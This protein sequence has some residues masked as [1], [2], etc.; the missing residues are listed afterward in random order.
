MKKIYSF[1]ISIMLFMTVLG[2]SFYINCN[3]VLADKPSAQWPTPPDI[4][5]ESAILMEPGTGAILYEKN[6]HKKMYP[7]SITKIMT[8]LLTLENC[9]MTDTV[10]YSENAIHSITTEDSNINCQIGEKM[11]VR[12]CLYALMLSSA[13][14]TA[15]A[16]AEHISGSVDKFADLMN[17]RAAQLGAKD[18]HFSNPNGLYADDHYVTAYDM[19]LIMKQAI[20]YP[21]FLDIIHSTVY[22]ILKNNKRKSEFLSY[23]RHKMVFT[24]SE[25]YYDGVIGG[26]TGYL[27]E[28]GKTLVTC[29]KKNNMT[30]ICVVLK[31][32]GDVVFRDTAALLDYGYD[33]F[34]FKNVSE[35]DDRF[36]TS[37][38]YGLISPF[39]ESKH[40]I[41]I[42]K[43]SS[44]VV[45]KKTDLSAL[46]T[47]VDFKTSGNSFATI[48]YS[49][50]GKNLGSAKIKYS[51][52]VSDTED[53]SAQSETALTETKV[54][55]TQKISETS[56]SSKKETNTQ[57]KNTTPPKKTAKI[58][59]IFFVIIVVLVFILI[60]SIIIIHK[61][62]MDKIRSMKRNR[63]R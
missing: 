20:Q 36:S 63:M 44:V 49:Y 34:T 51:A 5:G 37:D 4:V 48:T 33:N 7:A 10:V 21:A 8:A 30:L 6:C 58:S 59:P 40:S 12:D 23:Q 55:G 28:A 53:T 17:S 47:R 60:L 3:T 25:Y 2:Q 35:N 62:K 18:L 61:R 43:E 13:N 56:A 41:S 50:A 38:I 42:D 32:N 26:K 31:S 52:N 29:A 16:L 14:E 1:I 45:P 24:T 9:K 54:S 46:D 39:S 19:A 11:T 15:V 27:D 22:T 57:N